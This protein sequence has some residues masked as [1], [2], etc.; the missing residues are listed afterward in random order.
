M[1]QQSYTVE[2]NSLIRSIPAENQTN[3]LTAF[4]PSEKNP[5]V[6]FGFNVWL[7]W[8]GIDRFLVGDV[9][10]GVLKLLTFGGFG[11]WQ[12]IDCFL[13]GG[14]ARDKNIALARQM[15]ASFQSGSASSA[16]RAQPVAAPEPT[17]QPSSSDTA[18]KD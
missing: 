12:L 8:L 1:N 18:A 14:R 9:L 16:P 4:Q 5:V 3:F 11:I 10:A 6:L 2:L 17:V 15:V 13:I 7:G